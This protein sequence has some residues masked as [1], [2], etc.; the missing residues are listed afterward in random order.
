MTDNPT[1]VRPS[2]VGAKRAVIFI[3][4]FILTVLGITVI[5]Q[6]WDAVVLVFKACIGAILAV[7]GLVILFSSSL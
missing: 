6:Q 4:G 3:A 7:A 1:Q 2:A 5:I